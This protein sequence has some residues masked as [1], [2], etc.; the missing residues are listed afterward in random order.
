M[1][2]VSRIVAREKRRKEKEKAE[3]RGHEGGWGSG[4]G[5]VCY[6]CFP[7]RELSASPP[8][9]AVTALVMQ[10]KT[11]Y[12]LLHLLLGYIKIYRYIL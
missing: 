8:S 9:A 12:T 5:V 10:C 6:L 11:M 1:G 4:D 7:A 3:K 2:A